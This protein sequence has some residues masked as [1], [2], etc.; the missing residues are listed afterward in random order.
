MVKA[1]TYLAW[2]D[3]ELSSIF[4]HSLESYNHCPGVMQPTFYWNGHQLRPPP[5]HACL[6]WKQ[7]MPAILGKHSSYLQPKVFYEF[8]KPRK[9]K[10]GRSLDGWCSFSL[11]LELSASSSIKIMAGEWERGNKVLLR[12]WS[13]SVTPHGPSLFFLAHLS[14]HRCSGEEIHLPTASQERGER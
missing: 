1:S 3:G 4:H 2:K 11:L 6:F 12:L 7:H 9:V 10:G 8:A 13:T 14:K 5:F